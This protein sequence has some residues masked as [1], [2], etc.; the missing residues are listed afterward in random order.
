MTP[1][2]RQRHAALWLALLL[3][4]LQAVQAAKVPGMPCWARGPAATGRGAW[5]SYSAKQ[6]GQ[7]RAVMGRINAGV[8]KRLDFALF[9]DRQAFR[10]K[11]RCPPC[12]ARLPPARQLPRPAHPFFHH[13]APH[14]L[15]C[16]CC[17]S[18]TMI[19]GRSAADEWARLFPPA[20][21]W[22]AAP[23][24]VVGSDTQDLAW[25]IIGG[26]ERPKQ[27]PRVAAMLIGTND[28][29]QGRPLADLGEPGR[30]VERWLSAWQQRGAAAAHVPCCLLTCVHP[31][32]SL[33]SQQRK[34]WTFFSSGGQQR[35]L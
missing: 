5:K 20:D 10:E 4:P 35:I 3:A 33:P 16:P 12:S 26:W 31:L 14:N 34:R 8:S 32:P 15:P 25:R 29:N 2:A 17:R 9:G 21:G 7:N 6:G 30:H 11:H 24:G 27:S 1:T 13:A 22:L 23:F 28:V 18:I 19:L